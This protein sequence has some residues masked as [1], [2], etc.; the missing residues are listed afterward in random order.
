MNNK[1]ASLGESILKELRRL[2]LPVADL[3]NPG[4]S[5]PHQDEILSG[6]L[7]LPK[8]A[9]QLFGWRD[10][11]KDAELPILTLCLFPYVMFNSLERC[12]A[13]YHA[14][15]VVPV[16][17]KSWLPVFGDDFGTI[18]AVDC[19]SKEA[20]IIFISQS[21]LPRMKFASLVNMLSCVLECY[22][23]GAYSMKDGKL[24]HKHRQ[25]ERIEKN[26]IVA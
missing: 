14:R 12:I 1:V 21:E 25:V 7:S 4:L 24:E 8:P 13:D 17:R 26:W 11:T 2:E 6:N 18:Y 16:W 10:G 23:Q 19:K 15:K 20:S 9:Q 3:L 22:V 5:Q